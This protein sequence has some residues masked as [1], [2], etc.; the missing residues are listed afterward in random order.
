M[1]GFGVRT[2][3]SGLLIGSAMLACGPAWGDLLQAPPPA[4]ATPCSS[5]ATIAAWAASPQCSLG[6]QEL[7]FRKCRR[8]AH[9]GAQHVCSVR[10][11]PA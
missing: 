8:F 4:F 5:L 6:R 2:K 1:K 3:L 10:A 7:H 9:G 11:L